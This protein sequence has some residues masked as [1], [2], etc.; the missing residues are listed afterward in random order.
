MFLLVSF[1][2][3][4]IFDD[5][6]SF[7]HFSLLYIAWR[8]DPS[9]TCSLRTRLRCHFFHEMTHVSILAVGGVHETIVTGTGRFD[10][11]FLDISPDVDCNFCS[12]YR[13]YRLDSHYLGLPAGK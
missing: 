11:R 12:C 1:V 2:S 10:L 8:T 6:K 5:I 7:A 4:R 9:S 13:T 3:F